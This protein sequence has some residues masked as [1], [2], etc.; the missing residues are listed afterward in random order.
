MFAYPNIYAFMLGWQKDYKT[1]LIVYYSVVSM[2]IPDLNF[3][4][5]LIKFHFVN[6]AEVADVKV[7]SLP[8]QI[9][10]PTIEPVHYGNCQ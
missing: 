5:S 4:S 8:D 7:K 2:K 10:L 9:G 3:G 6:I 1:A